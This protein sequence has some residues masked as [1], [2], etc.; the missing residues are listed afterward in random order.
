MTEKKKRNS[1][2]QSL[3]INDLKKAEISLDPFLTTFAN[4]F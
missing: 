1:L 3:D 2:T 4:E